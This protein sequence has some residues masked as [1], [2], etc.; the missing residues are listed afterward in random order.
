MPYSPVSFRDGAEHLPSA[1]AAREA[2][3]EAALNGHFYLGDSSTTNWRERF[4]R[5]RICATDR[6]LR[7]DTGAG[8]ATAP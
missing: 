1:K 5:S 6:A 3:Q 2:A 4:E 8:I 7:T